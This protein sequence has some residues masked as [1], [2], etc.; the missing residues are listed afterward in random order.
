M[1]KSEDRLF[2]QLTL[3]I[4]SFFVVVSLFAYFDSEKTKEQL[5]PIV[6]QRWTAWEDYRTKNC[7]LVEKS[8]G[9]SAKEGKNTFHDNALTY[10]C[11]AMRYV[12][13][14]RTI[15]WAKECVGIDRKCYYQEN[16]QHI[17]EVPANTLIVVK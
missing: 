4:V 3:L 13:T 8:Y 17:P 12:V 10:Q 11:G 9:L 15:N 5:Y 7:T 16:I 6:K 1:R 2:V 14:E